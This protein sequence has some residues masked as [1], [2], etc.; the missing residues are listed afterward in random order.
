MKAA[1]EKTYGRKGRDVVEKNWAAI[2]AGAKNV[3]KV[4]VP[5]SWGQAEGE[6]YDLVH[7]T[8]ARQ[9]VVDFVNNIQVKVNAQEG[10]TVPVSDCSRFR[11]WRLCKWCYTFRRSCI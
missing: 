6:E 4:D 10:N 5:E 3:V 2:D 1:A 8:G 9:D 7:A 11:S